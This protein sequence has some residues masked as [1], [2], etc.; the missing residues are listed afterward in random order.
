MPLPIVLEDE[1]SVMAGLVNG[2]GQD[3]SKLVTYD[4][5]DPG[6]PTAVGQFHLAA[7]ELN[8]VFDEADRDGDKVATIHAE[9][10]PTSSI[11]VISLCEIS[12]PTQPTLEQSYTF[13]QGLNA[14]GVAHTAGHIAVAMKNFGIM[15]YDFTGSEEPEV[16]GYFTD[17]ALFTSGGGLEASGGYGFAGA[18]H[19]LYIFDLGL[20]NAAPEPG[21]EAPRPV[22]ASLGA[23]WPNPFN[24]S[25]AVP[26]QLARPGRVRISVHDLLGRR[27]KLLQEGP[28]PAGSGRAIW[29]GDTEQ[30]REA[31]SGLYFVRLEAEGRSEVR[32]VVLVR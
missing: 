6:I 31:A 4:L 19:S 29:R 9:G 32:R 18:G 22:T 5:A 26:F 25:V 24:S 10:P 12:D 28:A 17:P 16:A 11:W 3:S 14:S 1:G 13:G 23:P 8:L 27:V 2:V 20:P 7:P 21:A 30:R 15:L